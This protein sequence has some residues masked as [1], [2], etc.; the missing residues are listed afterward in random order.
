MMIGDNRG[1]YKIK[2]SE[3]NR[4]LIYEFFSADEFSTQQE[5]ADALGLSIGT[6]NRHVKA[7]RAGWEPKQ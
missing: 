2:Q 1:Q 3:E 6:V 7:I 5:C 4:I